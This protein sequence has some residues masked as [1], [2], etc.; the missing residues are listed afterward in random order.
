M[1][2][3]L[4]H[5]FLHAN[6]HKHHGHPMLETQAST[7]TGEETKVKNQDTRSASLRE[8]GVSH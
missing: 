8:A 7:S 6:L 2:W 1:H 3:T 5:V 4:F